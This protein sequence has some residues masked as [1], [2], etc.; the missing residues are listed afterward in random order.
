MRSTTNQLRVRG[1][2]ISPLD[3]GLN[4]L[5]ATET[6]PKALTLELVDSQPHRAHSSVLLDDDVLAGL[7][8]L[9][10]APGPEIVE[11]VIVVIVVFNTEHLCTK[12][13]DRN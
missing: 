8:D 12:M 2:L 1:N 5:G 3:C 11:H 4:H 13:L 9:G 7:V 6:A 10:V